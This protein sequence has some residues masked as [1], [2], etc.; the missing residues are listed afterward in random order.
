[1]NT[2]ILYARTPDGLEV[3]IIDVT[4]PAFKVEVT[5]AELKAQVAGFLAE[6]DRSARLP[7]FV[8][9]TLVRLALRS[10]RLGR[11]LLASY[12]SYLDAVST[13]LLKLGPKNLGPW[14]KPIDHRIAASLPA[15]GA[16][17]RLQDMARLAAD[18]LIR[19]LRASPDRPLMFLNLAGGTAIDSLNTLIVL[20]K[21][22][23]DV[24]ERPIAIEVL[25]CE[26]T[27]PEFGKRMLRRLQ[28]AGA[29]LEGLTIAYRHTPWDW[30]SDGAVLTAAVSEAQ[31]ANAIA[32]A[33]SEGG[34]FEY[35]T[36]TE[37]VDALARLR[38]LIA[39][40]GSVTRADEPIRRLHQDGRARTHPRGM[41]AFRKLIAP[42][43]W[44]VSRAIERPFSDQVSLAREEG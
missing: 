35:G 44:T 42:T 7:R 17:L 9:S 25:D 26:N 41:E 21:E 16:R 15:L 20:R 1:M 8:R 3:P 10:S 13:Y 23:G 43:G 30:Q 2:P 29:P 11:S 18:A 38:N 5:E 12:G 36:D 33:A 34:L 28:S 32:L 22:A 37:I 6:S 4:H 31:T 40:V 27:G 39:V 24:L 19:A 14:A